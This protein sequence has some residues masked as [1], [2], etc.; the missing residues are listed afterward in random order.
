[1]VARKNGEIHTFDTIDELFEHFL[2]AINR[3]GKNIFV[4]D[5]SLLADGALTR[6]N[7]PAYTVMH[8]HNSQAGDAQ[9]PMHSIVNNNYEYA[10]TNLD[11][12]S[13]VVSATQKQTNDVVARFNP[14][15]KAFTIPV[16]IVNDDNLHEDRVP[17]D[18]R[19]YGKII[20]VARIAFEK[21]LDDLVRAVNIV[22]DEIP[23]VTLDLYG[24]ADPS[25]NYGEK[26]RLKS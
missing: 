16:G 10:L 1:M 8:L 4:L 19:T 21:H 17:V 26:K 5:R 23:E 11:K 9:D 15:A 6:L 2:N 18:Q 12:Y 14:K 7:R 20:A 25:N 13:A 3:K 24:Y 22:H